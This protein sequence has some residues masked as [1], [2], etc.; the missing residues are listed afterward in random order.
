PKAKERI[1]VYTWTTEFN[2]FY[3]FREFKM[4]LHNGEEIARASTIWIFVDSTTKKPKRIPE[5]MV[6]IFS[7]SENKMVERVIDFKKSFTL[8]YSN[9]KKIIIRKSDIDNNN[10]VNNVKYLEWLIESTDD[11][12]LKTHSIK[13]ISIEYKKEVLLGDTPIVSS[14]IREIKNGIIINYKISTRK[15]DNVFA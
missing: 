9:D 4:T 1:K 5:A 6:N 2:K 8:P 13:D 11:K 3:A 10:H 15:T 12:L 14:Y 7:K